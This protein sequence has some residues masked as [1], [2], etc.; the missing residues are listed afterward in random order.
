MGTLEDSY[1]ISL[2][3]QSS[4]GAP[5]VSSNEIPYTSEHFYEY[6]ALKERLF[7]M[8]MLMNELNEITMICFLLCCTS[9][10]AM[11]LTILHSYYNMLLIMLCNL[12]CYVMFLTIMR[13]FEN[14]S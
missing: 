11:L 8:L 4:M 5:K 6:D 1:E 2:T 9:Y 13:F 12:L 3:V 14:S 10:Y 7:I